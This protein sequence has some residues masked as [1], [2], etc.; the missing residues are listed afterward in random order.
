M[1]GMPLALLAFTCIIAKPAT[2][3]VAQYSWSLA[4]S[5]DVD[6]AQV[7]TWVA[8]NS[9]YV[10][11]IGKQATVM[12]EIKTGTGN[13]YHLLGTNEYW[14]NGNREDFFIQYTGR[15]GAAH[16]SYVGDA[17]WARGGYVKWGFERWAA[18]SSTQES[19]WTWMIRD[20]FGNVLHSNR[21][22]TLGVS[23]TLTRA[24][25]SNQNTCT[26]QVQSAWTDWWYRKSNL[27][28]IQPGNDPY[29]T[30]NTGSCVSLS[31]QYSGNA[32]GVVYTW[33]N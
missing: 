4:V 11:N 17:A 16:Y 19:E 33:I 20:S 27:S 22:P 26:A 1:R 30:P 10:N 29:K 9:Q 25:I 31:G 8:N 5:D 12:H 15:D 18:N 6:V 14:S 7:A 28:W 13:Y 32:P 23:I 3:A 21:F 2:A 24:L